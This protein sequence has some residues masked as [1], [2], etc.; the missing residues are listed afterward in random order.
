MS[1]TVRTP[2]PAR[3]ASA[4]AIHRIVGG[5]RAHRALPLIL[6][7]PA[8]GA[9]STAR[10][11]SRRRPRTERAA[12]RWSGL[13]RRRLARAKASNGRA[14]AFARA[15]APRVGPA[16]GTLPA[17]RAA[18]ADRM[19]GSGSAAL[20]RTLRA[21]SCTLRGRIAERL[22]LGDHVAETFE[23]LVG[24]GSAGRRCADR[25]GCSPGGWAARAGGG[26]TYRLWAALGAYRDPSG[27]RALSA[28][29][30]RRA[31]HR[32]RGARPRPRPCGSPPRAQAARA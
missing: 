19:P 16:C 10:G 15:G 14:C 23:A 8:T 5:R 9:A 1:S 18:R 32:A 26:P 30:D 24:D 4:S 6:P 13:G 7:R 11:G 27:F 29:A 21:P 20:R 31:E 2:R 12:R 28:G 17:R 22:G 25:P 3:R